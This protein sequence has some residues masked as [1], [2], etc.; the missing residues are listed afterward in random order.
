M[1]LEPKLDP[2]DIPTPE[3]APARL[4][5]CHDADVARVRE[6]LD[7]SVEAWTSFLVQYS[8]LIH[9]MIRRYVRTRDDDDLRSIYVDVLESLYRHKLSTYQGRAALSTWL[10][11]VT[12]TAVLDFLRQRFGRRRP[13]KELRRLDDTE[14]TLFRMFYVEGQTITDVMMWLTS[15]GMRSDA[16][17]V[18]ARLR[19]I[20][21][22]LDRRWLMRLAY[23]LHAQSI[24]AAS[25]RLLE[26]LDHVR[27]QLQQDG[28]AL[29]PD[30]Q[31]MEREA[32][33]TV[34]CIRTTIARLSPDEQELLSLR[35][36]RGRTARQIAD[37]LGI[38]TPRD[39]YT[40]IDRIIRWLRRQLRRDLQPGDELP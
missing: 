33:Q 8:G 13:P 18:L 36:E 11:T 12:R 26:Y 10:T 21:S 28:A 25:G 1:A 23:D 24:G 17:Q 7:G 5:H 34:D 35:F 20:E 6:I 15:I 4:E 9:A 22:R 32:R 39:V 38:G 3:P 14:R 19:A 16:S 31:M 30:Y 40:R 27:D 29:D 2:A 37:E